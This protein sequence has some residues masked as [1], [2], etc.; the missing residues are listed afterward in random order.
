MNTGTTNKEAV[1]CHNEYDPLKKVITVSPRYM[2]INEVINQ[3]QE[4][5][6]NDNINQTKAIQQHANLISQMDSVGVD[7]IKLNEL[8]HLNEQVFT[9]DIGFT[10]GNTFFVAAM[11]ENIRKEEQDV[12]LDW[13]QQNK[14]AYFPF[15]T[16][17]IEGGDVIVDHSKVWVGI[18]DRTS[19]EA[20]A[21]LQSQ[22]P[23][24][25]V[26]PIKLRKDILHLDCIFNIIDEQT[27]LIYP[28]AM[29]SDAYLQLKETYTLIE[30][31][32][33]EQFHLGPNVLSLG[34]KQIISLPENK[35]MNQKLIEM[36]FQII[37]VPF[38][39]IIKSGGSFRCCTLPLFRTS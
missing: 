20:V 14:I 24:H 32:E 35:R 17:S 15:K 19:K 38:S 39:E 22:L 8:E 21:I 18:S 36:G 5:Y 12:L 23:T 6:V 34:N 4:H 11:K 13:L 7:V 37:E 28:P 29:D 10:I 2:Q 31:T 1:N 33:E 3:T 30:V 9:R 27:A 16:P 26:F 25:E